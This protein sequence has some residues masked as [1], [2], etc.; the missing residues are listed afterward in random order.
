MCCIY[1]IESCWL[2][3]ARPYTNLSRRN[4][5]FVLRTQLPEVYSVWDALRAYL[6]TCGCNSENSENTFLIQIANKEHDRES[7]F[8]GLSA[9]LIESVYLYANRFSIVQGNETNF[10]FVFF[11]CSKKTKLDF[12]FRFAFEDYKKT[13]LRREIERSALSESGT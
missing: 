1:K 11:F 7:W 12:D 6:Q 4:D 2:K 10:I 5:N 8:C 13:F 9:R 3:P